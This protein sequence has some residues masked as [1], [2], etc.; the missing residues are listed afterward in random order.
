MT[1]Q[2]GLSLETQ[3]CH[4]LAVWARARHLPLACYPLCVSVWRLQ[5]SLTHDVQFTLLHLRN[6][7]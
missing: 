2:K 7:V 5:K 6:E 3:L 1:Q 4:F